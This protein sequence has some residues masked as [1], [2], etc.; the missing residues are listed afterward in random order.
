[1]DKKEEVERIF[2]RAKYEALAVICAEPR[3]T[4]VCDKPLPEWMDKEQLAEYW[5]LE[6]TSGII[7]WTKRTE[8]PL[9]HSYMGDL[10]RFNRQKVDQWSEEEAVRKKLSRPK[11]DLQQKKRCH[12]SVAPPQGD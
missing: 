6:S 1:V 4:A 2:D 3:P 9:P 10:L 7:S 12:L 5:G 8:F 11:K